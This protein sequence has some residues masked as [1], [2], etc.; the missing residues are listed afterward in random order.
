MSMAVRALVALSTLALIM[1]ALVAQVAQISSLPSP[2]HSD[3]LRRHTE[4]ANSRKIPNRNF[5]QIVPYWTAE[6][7]WHTELQLRNNLTSDP[8]TV[9][10]ILRSSDGNETIL[11]DVT[12]LPGE[13]K[14]I[15]LHT[16]LTEINSA[17][18]GQSSAYGSVS[19]KYSTRSLRNLFASVMV[20]DTGRPIMYHLDASSEAPKFLTGSREGI[21]W[22][23]T[24]S[25]QGYLILTNQAKHPLA[26]SLSLYDVYGK[27]WNEAIQLE[28]RQTQRLSIRSLLTQSG[29]GG[30]FGGIKI[31]VP[32]GAGSLDS[33]N[34]LYDEPAGFS[35]TMKMFDVNSKI[36]V[37]QR[38]FAGT[39]VW[40]TRA[41]MLAL[42]RPDPVLALPAGTV[43]RPTIFLR[44]TT[45]KSVNVAMTLHWRGDSASG[46]SPAANI[47][48][49]PNETRSVNVS[50]MQSKGILP[51]DAHWAQA[52]I[53]TDSFPD[54]VVAA[55]ASYDSTL[56]YG[57][58]TPFSDQL[59]SHLEGGQWTV[60]ATHTSLIAIGNGSGQPTNAE[61]T[62]LY[63]QG[64]G[65]YRIDKAI[66]GD[67]QWFVNFAQLIREQVPDKDG[68]TI[69]MGTSTGA[70]RL[71]QLD[72][73]GHD[74]LYE[75]K[76]IT[77][78][79]YGHATYGCMTC[80]GYED[81]D[82]GLP[83]LMNDPTNV[84]IGDTQQVDVY[85]TN[86]CSGGID[87]LDLYFGSWSSG[88]TT[89]LT[90]SPT[91]AKGVGPG[92][93]RIR[94]Q[95]THLPSGSGQDQRSCPYAPD[96]TSGN[97]N[98]PPTVTFGPLTAVTVNGT[99]PVSVSFSGGATSS[100]ASITLSI[101][102]TSGTGSAVFSTGGTTTTIPSAPTT[103]FV[104][105]ITASST[106]NNMLLDATISNGDG[107]AP[108]EVATNPQAF[109]VVQVAI[110]VNLR[111]KSGAPDASGNLNF[112][113]NWSS[114]TG[115]VSDLSNCW[116]M[117]SVKYDG[118]V[119]LFLWPSPPYVPSQTTPNP[120]QNDGVG[121]DPPMIQGSAGTLPD[122]QLHPGFHGPYGNNT[123][124]A[125]QT[126]LWECS[127]LN[128][129]AFSTFPGISYPIV[130][131][132]SSDG[133]GGWMYT[134][135]KNG[136]TATVDPL[137]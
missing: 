24:Q 101:S 65:T 14:T 18:E 15:D 9:S 43:L 2:D 22:L 7:G 62:I 45:G 73:A 92:S 4:F 132:V 61:L 109:S 133:K 39:G 81:S 49:P 28:A 41:P 17:L 125:T 82:Y 99:V 46:Q 135:T 27:A 23:P 12:I 40:T 100:P 98:V 10:P 77:D 83:F 104:K 74:Y 59:S 97:G 129:G 25:T 113:Y 16:A 79:T 42:S 35:A 87:P 50:E 20:H 5:E 85:G 21:W 63:D 80:C 75:G 55:A 1:P 66:A 134:V 116:V 111:Q 105:G 131:T 36:Q 68:N 69:P 89:I 58:Q 76:V 136:V 51:M 11:R 72:N 119:P 121:T 93:T 53:V 110:P 37:Q 122:S 103:V 64:H 52:T 54:A 117:E 34:I 30:S 8:L 86:A 48:L 84:G 38:D 102:T 6:G 71:R 94:A 90:V 60:D 137:P 33:V 70:Y 126:F 29:L 120:T 123:V 96:I 13:V 95:A 47:A 88:D 112:I 44:N 91:F 128:N 124:T 57:A 56:R 19:L 115:S 130:R 114:S 106:P 31:D 26:C 32:E 127:N 3:V 107:G 118:S 67:D 108:Q 78:K